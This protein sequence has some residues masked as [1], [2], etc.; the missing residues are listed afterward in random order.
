MRWT[1]SKE[2]VV[3]PRAFASW[4]ALEELS[5]ALHFVQA[6]I[7]GVPAPGSLATRNAA[8]AALPADARPL[9]RKAPGLQEAEKSRDSSANNTGLLTPLPSHMSASRSASVSSVDA[10]LSEADEQL[11][12]REVKVYNG[13]L[14]K[15][16]GRITVK[17]VSTLSYLSTSTC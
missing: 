9:K 8:L 11:D 2:L 15:R 16:E 17:R 12:W 7:E 14:Q 4:H 13:I 1:T 3:P 6:Y 10:A 5:S